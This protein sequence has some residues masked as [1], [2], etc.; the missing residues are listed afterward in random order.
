M[1]VNP[2]GENHVWHLISEGKELPD[3]AS[4]SKASSIFKKNNQKFVPAMKKMNSISLDFNDSSASKSNDIY[5][6][7]F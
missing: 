4:N 5:K 7:N 1:K 6:R 3:E 2:N